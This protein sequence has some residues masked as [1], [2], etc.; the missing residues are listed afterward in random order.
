M[1]EYDDKALRAMFGKAILPVIPISLAEISQQAQTLAGKMSISG[2]QPKLSMRLIDGELVATERDG[3]YILKPQT[4]TFAQ[5]PQNEH[6][7]M[8]MGRRFG[9]V[10][11]DCLL[12]ELADGSPA[13]LVKRFDRRKTGRKIGKLSC[14]DMQQILGGSDKYAG[15]HEQIARAIGLHCTFGPIELQ[16]LFELMIFN[17]AIG[18]GDAHK[19]NFSLL[20]ASGGTALA[21]AYDL[22][23]SRLVIPGE[24]DELALTVG[25]KR[26]RLTRR[27]FDQ[28]A[29][30]MGIAADYSE[31]RI[32]QLVALCGEFKSMISNS[33]LSDALR[34]RFEEIVADRLERLRAQHG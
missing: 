34:Q 1:I 6:L 31:K 16:R 8:Q 27:D 30:H 11:A 3:R 24:S 33:S 23:S 26:N 25:G 2:I 12:M 28:L 21:P 29:E 15:S 18:N 19:K 22:V 20:T 7:C 17:F 13:Y 10:T 32:A 5:L 14:E 9:L 4:Q